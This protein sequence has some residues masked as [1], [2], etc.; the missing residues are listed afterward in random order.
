VKLVFERESRRIL[1]GQ[2][3][4]KVDLTPAINTISVCIQ[5]S[6]TVDDLAVV[7]FFFQPHFNNPWNFLNSAAQLAL[8]PV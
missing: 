4:S 5:N 8:P 7:D 6:M 3:M 1:G 2:L